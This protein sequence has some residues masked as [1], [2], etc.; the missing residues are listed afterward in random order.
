[1]VGSE[2][3]KVI[4]SAE[5]RATKTFNRMRGSLTSVQTAAASLGLTFGA[6]SAAAT[7]TAFVKQQDAVQQLEQRLKST[8]GVAGKTMQ[9]L[10]LMASGLQA[11]TRYGDEAT[12]EMQ[13][14][15]LTF[16]KVQGGVFDAATEAIMN[17]ATAMGT[18]LKSAALQVGKALNDPAGQLSALSRSGIQFTEDQKRTIKAMTDLGDVAGAQRVILAE[19]ETQFGGAARAARETLGGAIVGAQ[20]AMGDLAENIGMVFSPAVDQAASSVEEL[21]NALNRLINP[22]INQQIE[23]LVGRVSEI[24]DQIK[25]R[26]QYEG[27]G[28]LGNIFA[29]MYGSREELEAEKQRIIE[30]L[31]SLRASVG[32]GTNPADGGRG[33]PTAA[34]GAGGAEQGLMADGEA[35][36]IGGDFG[37]MD[38]PQSMLDRIAEFNGSKYEMESAHQI[39]M[40]DLRTSVIDQT[41][42][43]ERTAHAERMMMEQEMTD[44]RVSQNQSALGNAVTF[45]DMLGQKNKAAAIAGIAL[46][47]GIALATT[48]TSTASGA[49]LAYASQ[50]IP[51][52][53]TSIARA[54]AAHA[55]TWAMG[56]VNMALIA[57]TG[58][59]Q[60]A[61]VASGDSSSGGGSYTSPVVTQPAQ[62][63]ATDGQTITIVLK[64]MVDEAYV[65]ENLVP[66]LKDLSARRS[67]DLVF[68]AP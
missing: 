1:M 4:I 17:V 52:D 21:V 57:A 48:Y 15:L 26:S 38:N 68:E 56:K 11:V 35:F 43:V 36:R 40:F 53:P 55:S 64:G 66:T 16:T 3:A 58:L 44:F 30:Q 62:A 19:L 54:Q 8:G 50:L 65:E 49:Q 61:Q 27:R 59:F 37:L 33:W 14:L 63:G 32:T 5:D 46:Q 39:A 67:I 25:G 23:S 45:L 41:L 24:D 51:G 34:G 42:E 2:K 10:Q 12:L 9:D 20:N 13:A 60:A 7:V 29:A 31:N 22:N 28:A 47:K 6:L 18:D